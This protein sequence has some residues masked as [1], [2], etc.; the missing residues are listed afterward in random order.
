MAPRR[1]RRRP[2]L[3]G[4]KRE[5]AVR[6]KRG[7]IGRLIASFTPI[8]LWIAT[9]ALIGLAVLVLVGVRYWEQ[10]KQEQLSVHQTVIDAAIKACE[11]ADCNPRTD[12]S[13]TKAF[14]VKEH[15]EEVAQFA[16]K[17]V[18]YRSFAYAFAFGIIPAVGLVMHWVWHK[19][20]RRRHF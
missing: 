5:P 13:V 7:F 1:S 16:E 18:W 17:Q 3:I 20:T 11:M 15:L 14:E 2:A 6:L 10:A 8:H 9:G 12:P 4:P 19:S